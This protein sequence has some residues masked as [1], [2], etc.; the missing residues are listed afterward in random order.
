M[1]FTES[2]RDMSK[3]INGLSVIASNEMEKDS[4]LGSLF[5]FCSRHREILKCLYLDKNGFCLW[6]KALERD[7]P[8]AH[9]RLEYRYVS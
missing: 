3:A 1:T 8:H 5:L 4:L 2:F 6:Q 9:R 7:K